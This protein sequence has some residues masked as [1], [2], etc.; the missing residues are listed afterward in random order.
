MQPAQFPV[1]AVASAPSWP[2]AREGSEPATP[3]TGTLLALSCLNLGLAFHT[4][5][6]DVDFVLVTISKR[7]S[8]GSEV[9]PDACH[10][11]NWTR[12]AFVSPRTEAKTRVEAI[13][14]NSG[15]GIWD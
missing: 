2:G 14:A 11:A 15:K 1:S 4:Q 8:K 13:A 7:L 5:T 12:E 10:K 3:D 6:S 9:L